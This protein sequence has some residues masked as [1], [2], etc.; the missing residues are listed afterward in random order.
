MASG[1]AFRYLEDRLGHVSE[2]FGPSFA[3]DHGEIRRWASVTHTL[4][5][6]RRELPAACGSWM[7]AVQEWRPD[8]VVTDFEPLSGIYARSAQCRSSAWTTST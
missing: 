5:A 3:M 1:A 6:A 4:A 7:A 8:V 2:V